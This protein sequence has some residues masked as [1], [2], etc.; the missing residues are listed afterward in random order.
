MGCEGLAAK[1]WPVISSSPSSS[2]PTAVPQPLSGFHTAT[3]VSLLQG[4]A[5][6]LI[7]MRIVDDEGKE[8]PWDGKA[9]GNLQ[10]SGWGRQA[11]AGAWMGCRVGGLLLLLASWTAKLTADGWAGLSSSCSASARCQQPRQRRSASCPLVSLAAWSTRHE[12]M[13]TSPGRTPRPMP[14]LPQVRGPTSISRYYKAEGP[15]VDAHQWFDTG[16]VATI[17]EFGYMQVGSVVGVCGCGWGGGGGV[18]G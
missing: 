11:A 5:H 16:D 15:A 8:L 12:V 9:F 17:D 4:R 3:C 18:G 6:V 2:L 7:D 13:S 1:A 14:C 10:V